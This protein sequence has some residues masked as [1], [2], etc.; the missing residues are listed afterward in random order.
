MFVLFLM[1][2]LAFLILSESDKWVG[3]C[4][5]GGWGRVGWMDGWM[6]RKVGGCM[7]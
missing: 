3:E 4:V 1:L 6:S 7:G 5:G 2:W